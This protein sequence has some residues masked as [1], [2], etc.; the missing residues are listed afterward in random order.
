[1]QRFLDLLFSGL[2]LILL[3][4]IFLPI[5][6][7]L[8]LTGE[9]EVLF[10]QDRVGKHGK[11]FKLY[12][13]ATMLKD[14][15]NIGMGT[16]TV[17]NDPRILPIGIFLRKTKVNE[18]PQL[19]NVLLGSMSIIGP[20]PQAKRNFDAFPTVYQETI[21][22]VKPGL[23]GIGSIVFRAEEEILVEYEGNA[24]FYTKII[25]PYKGELEAWYVR[26]CSML[27]YFKLIL[28][29]IWVLIKPASEIVWITFKDLPKPPVELW[30][31]LNY[32]EMT[33]KK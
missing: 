30:G 25:A 12:K 3:M 16:I 10:L 8:R 21:T 17:K 1:M 19:L 22:N 28:I 14:S 18:L 5:S 23:S 26:N 27:N 15:P 9:G 11:I 29:T 7:I 6:I 32:Y 33:D 31:K 2:A 20:R 4:P 24:D 13:F